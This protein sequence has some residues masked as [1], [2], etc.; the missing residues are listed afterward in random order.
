M[1][2]ISADVQDVLQ[3]R[4]SNP[5]IVHIERAAGGS[6]LTP[7]QCWAVASE[8]TEAAPT[9]PLLA[10]VLKDA[11]VPEGALEQWLLLHAALIA[12]PRLSA[13]RVTDRVRQLLCGEFISLA[14]AD[15]DALRNMPSGR[16]RFVGLAKM[17]TLRR[18]P[19]GQFDWDVS[20]ISRSDLMQI[21]PRDLPRTISFMVRRM[22]ALKP[23]FFSHLSPRRPHR[24][25]LETEANRS[26]FQ[27][28][29]AMMLQPEIR[30][31]A[32]CSW[33]RSPATHRVSPHL[34]WLSEVFIENGGLVV[35]AGAE[36]PNGGVLHRSAT[37][38]RLFEA[39][40]FKPTRGLVLWPR[41]AMIAW[42]NAHPELGESTPKPGHRAE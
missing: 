15:G 32:A 29:A 16:S 13:L 20:G 12:V 7:S 1:T 2:W 38:R 37:R 17:V 31:F 36:D 21:A 22:R 34:A 25:L 10:A 27:M 5:D 33:F 4:L 24:H 6:G 41:Q 40:R 30:G 14:A 42:A 19:A 18:F 28:A 11:R 26:Y 35:E 8:I 3:R 39:G 23:V 9:H